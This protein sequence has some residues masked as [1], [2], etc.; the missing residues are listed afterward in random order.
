M[1]DLTGD[2]LSVT[3]IAIENRNNLC[4][5]LAHDHKSDSLIR[6]MLCPLFSRR[7]KIYP[8]TDLLLSKY[9]DFI[10][11][12]DSGVNRIVVA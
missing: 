8:G 12:K 4:S 7:L 10:S 3:V 1:T 6:V 2:H 11:P 5:L 9:T